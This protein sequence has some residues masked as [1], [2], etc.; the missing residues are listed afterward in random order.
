MDYVNFHIKAEL[1][2]GV[3][4]KTIEGLVAVGLIE[5]GPNA[6]H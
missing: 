5:A 4:T 2:T 3:G 1:G 6:R